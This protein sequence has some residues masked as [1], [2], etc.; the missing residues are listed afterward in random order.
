LAPVTPAESVAGDVA[1]VEAALLHATPPRTTTTAAKAAS[2]LRV[3]LFVITHTDA[4]PRGK[5]P[6]VF[7][8]KN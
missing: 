4:R 3:E 6:P 5:V 7:F 8:E 1:G 2:L